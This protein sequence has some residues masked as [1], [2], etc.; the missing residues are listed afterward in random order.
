MKI[1]CASLLCV[2][3]ILSLETDV[4]ETQ[5]TVVR[6]EIC[7]KDIVSSTRLDQ[8]IF[9]LYEFNCLLTITYFYF[10]FL[11]FRITRYVSNKEVMP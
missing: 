3:I 11:F 7:F 9:I 8:F 4:Q 5:N 2:V 6:G 10:Y 1:V